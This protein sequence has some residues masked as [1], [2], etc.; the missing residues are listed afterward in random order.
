MKEIKQIIK[1]SGKYD[2]TLFSKES[3]DKLEKA[4]SK[5]DDKIYL[6]CPIRDKDI[7]A[8]PEEIV[9][10]LFIDKLLNEFNYPKD[11]IRVLYPI[12][13]GREKKQADIIIFDKKDKSSIYCV[14]EIKKHKEKEGKE[15]LKSYTNATG[16]PL[17]VWTN[18]VEINIFERLDP[19]YFEPI[20]RF[21][22]FN[23]EIE[24]VKNQKFTYLDLMKNDRLA[25]ERKSLK[26]LILEMENEVLA[27]AGVDIFEEVFKLIF[28]KLYDEILSAEDRREIEKKLK[29]GKDLKDLKNEN[30]F[31]N[32]EFRTSGRPHK[33]KEKINKLFDKAKNEWGGIFDKEEPIKISDEN[34]L[35][36]CIGFL[37]SVKLFN[38]NLQVIDEAFEYLVNKSAKGEKGQYFTPRNVIDMAVYMLNPQKE[39]KMIDTACGSCGFTIHTLFNVWEKLE[40]KGKAGFSNFSNQELTQEKKE[41]VDNVFGIDFDER[42][43]RTARTLN[44]IA[45]DGK[46]N[47]IHLNTLDY[48]RWNEKI[49]DESW[50]N[51][52][53][54]AYVIGDYLNKNVELERNKFK[55]PKD[56][57][58]YEEI[59]QIKI[60]RKVCDLLKEKYQNLLKSRTAKKKSSIVKIIEEN[61]IYDKFFT[62]KIDTDGISMKPTIEEVAKKIHEVKIGIE[63]ETKRETK[64]TL[65]NFENT[66]KSKIEEICKSL[67]ENQK[68][69]LGHYIT[70]RKVYIDL[71]E[72]SLEKNEEGK[73]K[74]EEFLHEIIFPK[75]RDSEDTT[76]KEHNLWLL[77]ENLNFVEYINSDNQSINQSKKRPDLLFVH[78]KVTFREGEEEGNPISIFEF[79]RQGIDNFDNKSPFQQIKSYIT[80][81]R[82]NKIRKKSG[83]LISVGED[84]PFYCYIVGSFSKEIEDHLKEENLKKLPQ[85]QKW[86]FYNDNLKAHIEYIT[87]EELLKEAEQRNS[88]FFKKLGI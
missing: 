61:F 20:S 84:T 81:I 29:R 22:N 24:D 14:I 6:K 17:A 23:E 46:T 67:K 26:K 58:L 64:E 53:F 79:K 25:K 66:T 41:V 56:K 31:R 2:L 27:N 70:L 19:N 10:Q 71:L 38:S 47:V 50:R 43:V 63:L 83:K 32:L 74:K 7:Q 9:Q 80:N 86:Y 78:E 16:S 77:D 57:D 54:K 35:Q 88:I 69:E 3:I 62:D 73:F 5:K 4:L 39:E 33:T 52:I 36:I 55:I 72:K 51:Y 42:A 48:Q 59:S 60:E 82:K 15:Q 68:S 65:N 87:W 75:G 44:M 85:K 37:Q 28:T 21:P 11:L 49:K 13:F 30:D 40:N 76:F 12:T 18:G 8:K 34:H 1:T 45:G